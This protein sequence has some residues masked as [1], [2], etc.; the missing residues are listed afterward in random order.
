MT[1]YKIPLFAFIA[2]KGGVGKSTCATLISRIY[3]QNGLQ[4]AVVD[5]DPQGTTTQALQTEEQQDSETT[6]HFGKALCAGASLTHL[7]RPTFEENLRLIPAAESLTVYAD[8]LNN[9]K[10]GVFKVKQ[11]LESLQDCGADIVIVD[12]PGN[13]GVFTFG[14]LSAAS[15]AVVPTFCQKPSAREVPKALEAIR[16]AKALNP[17]LELLGVIAGNLDARTKHELGVLETLRLAFGEKLVEPPIPKATAITNAMEPG[18]PLYGN[19]QGVP[20]LVAV[21]EELLTRH[22][23]AVDAG[24]ATKVRHAG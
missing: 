11:S 15:W 22:S 8:I 21:A 24:D 9:D 12:T 16:E 3:A 18:V 2:R 7:L 1:A 14:A 5:C 17:E 10:M 23:A 6:E 13:Y 19:N 4:V 20:A